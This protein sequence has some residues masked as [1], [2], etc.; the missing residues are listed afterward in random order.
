MRSTRLLLVSAAVA[1]G[2][3]TAGPVAERPPGPAQQRV[4]LVQAIQRADYQGDRAALQRLHQEL[5]AL[6][7]EP[8]TAARQRY[9]EGF[10]LWRR[11]I[12]GANEKPMPEDLRAD[13]LGALSDFDRSVA[14]DPRFDDSNVGRISC[15][16]F[17]AFLDRGDPEKLKESVGRFV[18]LFKEVSPR[19]QDNPRFQWVRGLSDWYTPPGSSP[20]V[21]QQ[22]VEKAQA[23]YAKGA[24]L[25]R[26]Q[27]GRV[28]DPLDPS[29]GEPE[30]LMS[31][32]WCSLHKTTPDPQQ[33]EAYA[34]QALALVP[35]W[36]YVRDILLPQIQ[37]AR[38]ER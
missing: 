28:T 9:W 22:H 5:S 7:E 17:L 21:V 8:A 19:A 23:T 33:A 12:N 36:H 31:L 2:C 38:A 29:W 13:L 26:E 15:L 24:A 35:D 10:A 20:E 11:A 34:R 1:L 14:A 4:A 18:A 3:N 6:P 16:Q 32:A 30:N 25:A 27:K 37:S